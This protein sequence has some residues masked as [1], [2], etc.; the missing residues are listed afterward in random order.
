VKLSKVNPLYDR[1]L[2]I[3]ILILTVLAQA[4]IGAGQDTSKTAKSQ[5]KQCMGSYCGIYCLYSVMRLYDVD[6][7]PKELLK[8]EYIGSHQGS[9]LAELKKAAEDHDLYAE[10]VEKL[11]SR[12]LLESSYPV[13][14]H[15]KS[16]PE[17]KIYN[18]YELLLETKNGQARLYN[19]PEPVRLVPFYEFA[20]RWDGTG[21]VVSDTPIDLGIIFAPARRRFIIYAAIA[22]AL[23]LVARWGRRRWL[24]PAALVSRGRLFGA[25]IAASAGLMLLA[26][27]CGM[28]C[29]FVNEEGFLA[30][31]NG[32]ASI[33]KAYLGSFI[34][35][36]TKK[37]VRKLLNT[38][39]VFIDAGLALDF[40][41]GHHL[42][43][44]LNIPANASDEER[45]KTMADTAKD[46]RLVVYSQSTRRK[47]AEVVAIKLMSDGFSNVSIFRGGWREWEATNDK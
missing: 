30:H 40:E 1:F 46:A 39:T 22:V 43:G 41:A 11:T 21:L 28:L 5:R 7:D 2:R 25:S 14:L 8:P 29:H 17:M 36:I 32:T 19:P 31:T 38:D 23:I 18:H 12:E 35:K 44:A 15:V 6:V 34:P 10:P 33:K 45:Q 27:L 42:E 9:S 47:F 4:A 37:E 24:P 20:P 26:M 13:I 16:D 3:S